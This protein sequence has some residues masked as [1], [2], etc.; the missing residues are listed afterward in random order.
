LL[1]VAGCRA[2]GEAAVIDITLDKLDDAA[3]VAQSDGQA[4]IDVTSASGIG[5]FTAT[6]A[7]E[8]WPEEVVVRLHTRGLEQLFIRYGKFDIATGKSSNDSPDPALMLY[9]EGEDGQMQSAPPSADIYYPDIRVVNPDPDRPQLPAVDG[10]FE[11]TLPP[12]FHRDDYPS[13]AMQWIDF[14]R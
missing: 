9:V 10:Y 14:Y 12:H 3:T 1:T 6:L 13:F 2:R 7:E 11:I 8:T 4:L 5:G